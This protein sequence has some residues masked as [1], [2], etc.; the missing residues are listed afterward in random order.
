LIA[1][2]T[3]W[4]YGVDPGSQRLPLLFPSISH[5]AR[6]LP[7]CL[8]ERAAAG[9]HS[10]PPPWQEPV[11]ADLRRRRCGEALSKTR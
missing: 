4:P 3:S 5:A 1:P 9:P 2:Q 6:A 11:I 10:A 7:V 8:G